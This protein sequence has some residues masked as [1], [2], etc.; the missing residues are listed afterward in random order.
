MAKDKENRPLT[1]T[2]FEPLGAAGHRPRKSIPTGYLVLVIALMVT[3]SILSY[4]F[5]AKAVIFRVDPEHAEI[6]ISGISFH[7]GDNFLLLTGEHRLT[8]RADGYLPHEQVFLVDDAPSQEIEVVLE[9]LPGNLKLVSELQEIEVRIDD[10]F[11]GSAPGVIEDIPRGRHKIDFIKHRYFPQQQEIDIEGLGTTQTLKI[12]LLPAW[13]QMQFNSAPQGADVFV[14]NQLMGKTPLTTEILETG[15]DVRLALFGYK[16]WQQEV[17][18]TAGQTQEYPT[19]ELTIADGLADISSSPVGASVTIDAEFRGNTPLTV[20]LSP[21]KAHT[22]ELYLEGFRKA[23]RKVTVKPELRS[24]VAVSLSP[25][26]GNIKLKVEPNDADVLVDNQLYG[27]GSQVLKLTAKQH[28][29]RIQKSGYKAQSLNVTPRPDHEQTLDVRLLTLQQD[30]WASRPPVIKSPAGSVLKLFRV[31]AEFG[32]GAPRREPGRRA[33]EVEHRVRLERP[34]YLGIHEITNAE[35]RQWREEHSSSAVQG[36]SLDMDEQP[37]VNV[38][39]QDAALF[40]NWL[41]RRQGLPVFYVVENDLVTG[42]D[43]ESHGYRLPTEAEWSWAARVDDA[44]KAEMFPWGGDLYPPPRVYENYADMSAANFLPFTISTYNDG[45]PVA[46]KTGSFSPNAKGL[47]D[48]SGNVAEWVNDYYSIQPG[49]DGLEMD[50]LGPETGS[51]H[52]IRGASW[53]LGSRP[54]LRLSYR[55]AGSDGRMDL[56]F[57]IARYVD[58][59]EAAP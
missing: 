28:S 4:L 30:Y 6:D 12:S 47:Y 44:G 17:S 33:N 26:I 19:I 9:P 2:E 48:L 31:D 15:S 10:A 59:T 37:V 50:P 58:K 21:L 54:K 7:I 35:F 16:T 40:C 13:G 5:L 27:R 45:Y 39:W 11:A 43:P 23:V 24:A 56:G 55:D 20:P 49:K 29:V 8:A 57:R 34:F 38:T 51:R 1:A 18:V 22:I 53:A 14:D 42:F 52:T 32:M 36:Q 25:I 46:A 3:A 41:S